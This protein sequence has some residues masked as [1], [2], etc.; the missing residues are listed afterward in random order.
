LRDGT[1]FSPQ[2]EVPPLI[3]HSLLHNEMKLL[4]KT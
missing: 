1:G 2:W 4:Q 3:L